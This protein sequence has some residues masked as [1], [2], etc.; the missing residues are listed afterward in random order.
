MQT[1]ITARHFDLTDEMKAHA[2]GEIEGLTRYFDNI[3]SAELILDK[4]R[5]RRTAELRVKVY[6]DTL[7]GTGDTDDLY[8]SIGV[9]VDKVKAQLKKYKGKL[10]ERRPEEIVE[11]KDALTKPS[12]DPDSVDL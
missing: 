7:T 2:E 1:I 3:I 4:E 9:A 11:T 10:K 5:H 8:N 12:T 6:K